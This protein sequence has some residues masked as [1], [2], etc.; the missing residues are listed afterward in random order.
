MPLTFPATQHHQLSKLP[1]S[2]VRSRFFRV[3][4]ISSGIVPQLRR[5]IFSF[6]W[7]AIACSALSASA[8]AQIAVTVAW[9]ANPETNIAGYKIHLGTTSGN[10][11]TI[12]TVP[13]ATSSVLSD[14]S[15][16]TTY[17]CALQA[18]NTAGLTSSLSSE[19]SFTTPAA[20]PEIAVTGSTGSNLTDGTTTISF[21]ATSI[22]STNAT[23]VI[24]LSNSGTANLTG[25][26]VTLDGANSSDFSVSAPGASSLAAGTNTTLT[27]TFHPATSGSRVAALHIA[28]NDADE[29]P[30][31]IS[32]SGSGAT[33]VSIFNSW[34]STGGLSGGAAAAAATPF[35]DGVPNMLKFAFNMNAAGPDVRVLATGSGTAGL[36]AFSMDRSGAQPQFTVEFLR[37]K[38]SGLVY[39]PKVSSDLINFGPMTGTTTVT[40]VSDQWERV[41]LKKAVTTATTPKLFGIVEVSL[42]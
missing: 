15:P 2:A 25:L 13:N 19:I 8:Q 41:I 7:V 11:T 21:G 22:G 4:R 32:L 20:L 18:Y 33:A 34:A 40:S 24:T 5:F 12:Q 29:A 38:G 30:F 16:S 3:L 26:S 14:L 23:R 9:N 6:G 39:T 28:S 27:V 1:G 36:P 10:Y 42:P 17:F 35:N 31:D 37:R